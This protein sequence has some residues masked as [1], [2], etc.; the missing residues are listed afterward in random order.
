MG[1][2]EVKNFKV[3]IEDKPIIKDISFK[4]N[5]GN[6]TVIMGRNGSGKSS[7]AH[8]LAG[9]P[10]FDAQ[11][12]AILD[13][14]ELLELDANERSTAGLFLSFQHPVE[15]DGVQVDNFIRQAVNARREH[16]IRISEFKQELTANMDLLHLKPEFAKRSLNKGFSGGEKKKMEILQLLMLKPSVAIL[17]ET[18]SGLDIDA[19]REVCEGILKVKQEHPKMS[20]IVI[21]HYQRILDYLHPDNVLLLHDG[22]IIKEGGQELI[23]LIEKGGYEQ[24]LNGKEK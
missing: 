15:I 2:L 4:T 3:A 21:T 7:I 1:S 12:S 10:T 9:H 14:K 16:P 19:L 20:I 24:L 22:Q 6:I 17:D 5:P 23:D 8:A 11:G 13:G 18:D